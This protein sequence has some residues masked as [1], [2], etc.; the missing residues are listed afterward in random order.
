MERKERVFPFLWIRGEEKEQLME[1]VQSIYDCGLRAFCIESRVHPDFCGER[2]FS[3]VEFLLA[4]AKK[5]DMQVWI[6]DDRSYPTGIANHIIEKKYPHLK[7]WQ[8]YTRY[9]DVAG[10]VLRAKI[11]VVRQ[12]NVNET[13]L[14]V[15][16]MQRT[17]TGVAYST[18]QDVSDGVQ[19]DVLYLDI[20]VGAYR[21]YFLYK[22][23]AYPERMNYV[24]MMNKSSVNA[25][26]EAVYEPHYERLKEYFGTTLVGFFSDEPRLCNGKSAEIKIPVVCCGLGVQG[27]TYPYSE[28]VER[29]T[30]INDRKEWLLLWENA[31]ETAD[32]RCRYMTA[33]TK[34]YSENFNRNLADWCHRHGVMYCGHIIEDAGAHLRTVCSAGHYFRS[35]EG[36][37]MSGVDIVLHQI[38]PYETQFPH[39]APQSIGTADPTFFHFTLPKLASSCAVLDETKKGDALCEAFGAYGWGEST[40][41]MLYIANVMLMRGINC[42]IPH[43]FSVGGGCKDCPPHFYE[44]G[45]NPAYKGYQTLFAYLSEMCEM[46]SQGTSFSDVAILYHDEAEWS[47]KKFQPCDVVAKEMGERQI[48]YDFVYFDHIKDFAITDEGLSYKGRKYAYLLIPSCRFLTEETLRVLNKFGNRVI[49][50]GES[51]NET[52]GQRMSL[53]S[54]APYLYANGVTRKLRSVCRGLRIYNYRKNGKDVS[55]LFNEEGKRISFRLN[56]K[57]IYY[58]MDPVSGYSSQIVGGQMLSLE[59][60]QLLILRTELQKS[61]SSPVLC[62]NSVQEFYV[63]LKK[64]DESA[65]TDYKTVR[66]PFEINDRSE[67]PNFCGEIRYT[68]DLNFDECNQLQI[69]YSGEFCEVQIGE[70]CQRTIGGRAVVD[71]PK[72]C[73]KQTVSVTIANT[74]AYKVKDHYTAYGYYPSACL[75]VVR[76][77]K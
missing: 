41:E 52:V 54:L 13:L 31:P 70:F 68:F 32:L 15:Y 26:I 12:Q 30:G 66:L 25:L 71:T 22:T 69:E 11:P 21:V 45:N 75:F 67:M 40:T 33:I 63:S 1:E 8:I 57:R 61:T 62:K 28:E 4:E 60:G 43:A 27:L 58:A 7:G 17:A 76:Y 14:G 55:L 10:E 6:L 59:K 37:D 5:R 48:D 20:P 39:R 51:P 38:K 36:A 53:R 3:D 9:V 77:G 44:R 65:F 18:L 19:D 42:F 47:G 16:L 72:M 50:V 23:Q 73:G 35:M 49:F 29:L 24:D 46:L 34:K 74:L 56:D 64:N 2:W